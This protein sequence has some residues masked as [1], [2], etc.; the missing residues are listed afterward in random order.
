MFASGHGSAAGTAPRWHGVPG[1]GEACEH[2]GVEADSTRARRRKKRERSEPV[3]W[4]ASSG[5]GGP[6]GKKKARGHY[7]LCRRWR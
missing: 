1:L 3:A 5:H 7:L 4:T 2:R 6:R